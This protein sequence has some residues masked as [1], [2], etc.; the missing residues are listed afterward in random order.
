MGGFPGEFPK[1]AWTQVLAA[2]E[3]DAPEFRAALDRLV[4]A[5]WK[6]V[7]W[8][9]R[10]HWS[11]SN[12]DAK[13]LTQDFFLGFLER[14][15]LKNVGPE[16]GRFRTYVQVMLKNFLASQ[17]AARRA[18]KRG[19]GVHMFSMEGVAEAPVAPSGLSGEELLDRTWAWTLFRAA[20]DDLRER[21]RAAG[22]EIYF[23][24]FEHYDLSD[25]PPAREVLA[26]E[27]GLS[28]HD[29]GNYLRHA[30]AA[31][32]EILRE[33]VRATLADE[34]DLENEL[35]FLGEALGGSPP[36]G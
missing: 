21:Y 11:K 30:R 24:V 31:F 5:Y 10:T 36:P 25:A 12:E 3:R 35:R 16:K 14:D 22:R 9:I 34:G 8:V 13:D 4:Q 7:Y 17:E 2:K 29:V 28:V 19:G 26:K 20:Q 32:K 33:R 6:P 27:L 15:R 23:T 1:T 18:R